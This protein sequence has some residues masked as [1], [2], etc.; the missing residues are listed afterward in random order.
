MTTE[1]VDITDKKIGSK[2]EYVSRLNDTIVLDSKKDSTNNYYYSIGSFNFVLGQGF[3]PETLENINL[4]AVP[5][6]PDWYL[7]IV[8]IH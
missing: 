7:G 4:T 6:L 1:T 3:K 8:S 2:K 5:F